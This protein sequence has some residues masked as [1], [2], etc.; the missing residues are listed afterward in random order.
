[1]TGNTSLSFNIDEL[2]KLNSDIADARHSIQGNFS[3]MKSCFEDLKSNVTG[4]Q[5][6]SLI[7]TITDNLTAID[8]KMTTSF[9]QLSAFL[10]S[11]MR[12]YAT[13]YEGAKAA[14]SQALSFI[15]NNL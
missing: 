7:T 1:M 9:D 6:N 4:T 15:D 12:N 5:I 11:Q 14:L 2:N 3:N 10:S 13:T 8:S